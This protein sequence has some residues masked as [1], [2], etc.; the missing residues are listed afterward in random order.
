MPAWAVEPFEIRDIRVEGMQRS[1]PGT[2]FGALPFRIGDTYND[3]KGA[4][5]LRAL[6][7]TGLFKDV[8]IDLEGPVVVLVVDE[9]SFI[10]AVNFSGLREFDKDTILKALKDNGIGEG[11]PFDK[12]VIDRAE[13]EIKRQYL[14][15]S[16]YGAEVVTTATPVERNRV[17][18]TFT[19]VEG[20]IARIRDI[21]ISGNQAYSQSELLDLLDLTTGGWMT[22]YTKSD[23]YARTKLNADLEKIRSFYLNNGFLEFDIKGTLVTMSPDKQSIDIGITLHEGRPYSVAAVR[24]EGEYLGREEEFRT[25]VQIRPGEPYRG[26]D[27][28]AT[29]RQFSEVFANYGY[30]FA[31]VEQRTELD[32]ATGTVTVVLTGV[33]GLRVNVRR[34]NISG[35]SL[36]RD[37]VIRREFR[38]FES[39]WYDGRKIKLSRDRVERLGYFTEVAV[40]TQEVPGAPDQVDLLLR[41][42]EKPTGSL[43]LS[44]GY[45]TA[46]RLAL[47]ASIRKENIFGTGNYLGIDLNTSRLSRSMM[48]S[49]VDPYY[50]EDGI[51]RAIEV[52]YRT[53]RPV[54]SLGSAYTLATPGA[55][56]R[57][58]IPYTETDTVFVGLGAEQMRVGTATG[59]PLSYRN[60]VAIFGNNSTGFP[61][62]LGWA[63]EERDNPIAPTRGRYQRVNLETSLVGDMQYA[64]ANY[65]FQ[66]YLPFLR[67][68]TLGLNAELGWG[69]GL[70]GRPY[71]VFKNFYGGG[72]GSVRV[73]E[74]SSLGAVDVTGAY[75][76]GNRRLN[77]NSE[78]YVPLPGTGNDKTLRIFGFVDAGNV[79]ASYQPVEL[80]DLRS[81][82]GVG[83]SWIS[84]VGPLKLSYGLPLRAFSR[85]KIQ[86]LQFQ[87][88][89]AF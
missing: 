38:Q 68:F 80:S 18:V 32:R 27:V 11:M 31:R 19:V 70:N 9:R 81:S 40:E 17:D 51:S 1:D 78:L 49:T 35:N 28:S 83:L 79:W 89:T 84:P 15:R 77:L 56:I 41:V 39:A 29:V 22:W 46:D 36:T 10:A 66:Q 64:R 33:P 72:L 67:K 50:T 16:F 61:V 3:E 85:D 34:I 30:A 57:F 5:A 59:I 48:V 45:S 47:T 7:A 20:E 12:A 76:G 60:H 8:R 6:F 88:G 63:R 13:Q 24:M 62:T 53:S 71:P 23:R 58:G 4:A 87:I 75:N 82:Y 26:D 65:Q 2:V 52:Y 73:F 74:Q 86:R 25:K 37:D 54:N 21:S 55:T 43:M 42:V 14:T 44:A 69:E